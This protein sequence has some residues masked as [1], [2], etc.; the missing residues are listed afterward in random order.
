MRKIITLVIAFMFLPIGAF[1]CLAAPFYYTSRVMDEYY[2]YYPGDLN[3]QTGLLVV[4]GTLIFFIGMF[5]IK[6]Y[7][8]E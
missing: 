5:I 7:E 1:M 8:R 6:E 4:I 3:L 2:K